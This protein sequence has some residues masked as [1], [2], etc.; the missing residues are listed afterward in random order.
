MG[1]SAQE[2]AKK[3]QEKLKKFQNQS[4]WDRVVN[5]DKHFYSFVSAVGQ[6]YILTPEAY[7]AYLLHP[8]NPGVVTDEG[9][10]FQDPYRSWLFW[11]S[12]SHHGAIFGL[13]MKKAVNENKK[14]AVNFEHAQ[15]TVVSEGEDV[16]GD[17][18]L[19][20]QPERTYFTRYAT[21]VTSIALVAV[22]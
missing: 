6:D 20:E 21:I 18:Y 17:L 15:V 3:T 16:E 13:V 19:M 10:F 2:T 11:K 22:F 5:G 4:L 12:A 14:L 9:L 1:A 7:K 8:D